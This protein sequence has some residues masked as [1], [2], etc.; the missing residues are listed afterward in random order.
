[1]ARYKQGDRVWCA[2]FNHVEKRE[3]C[4]ICFGKK[5]VHIVLGDESWIA[6]PCEFCKVGFDGPVGT[7]RTHEREARA[8]QHTIAEVSIRANLSGEDVEYTTISRRHFYPQDVFDNQDDALKRAEELAKEATER[9]FE[10]LLR[11]K[12]L[13]EKDR[14]YSWGVGYHK[15]EAARHRKDAEYHERLCATCKERAKPRTAKKEANQQ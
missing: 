8:E 9:E 12:A 1:M 10:A 11:R 2:S 15:R 5:Q 4:P 13:G 14:T 3:T 7:I 6:C